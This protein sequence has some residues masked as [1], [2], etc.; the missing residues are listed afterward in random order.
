MIDATSLKGALRKAKSRIGIKRSQKQNLIA[1]RKKEILAKLE[2]GNETMAL[3]N[4]S[5]RV[6]ARLNL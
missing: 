5:L 2:A 1:K 3:I 4:V 6:D